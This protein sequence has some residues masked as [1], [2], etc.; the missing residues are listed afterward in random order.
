MLF[1]PGSSD[2]ARTGLRVRAALRLHRVVTVSA[3]IIPRQL[4]V[5]PAGFQT[6]VQ[7]RLRELFAL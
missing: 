4:G 5:L 1:D 2:F 6:Q 3:A 7:Q